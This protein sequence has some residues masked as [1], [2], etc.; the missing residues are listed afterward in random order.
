MT[1][2]FELPLDRAT[3][4]AGNCMEKLNLL[5]STLGLI[6]IPSYMPLS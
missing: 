3:L 4:R 6:I 2:A 5:K 1:L